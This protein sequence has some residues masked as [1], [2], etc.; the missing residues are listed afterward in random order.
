MVSYGSIR[1]GF[2]VMGLSGSVG[3]GD[4]NMR[5]SLFTNPWLGLSKFWVSTSLADVILILAI[6]VLF[7]LHRGVIVRAMMWFIHGVFPGLPGL[8]DLVAIIVDDILMQICGPRRIWEPGITL[9]AF[10]VKIANELFG[11]RC[12]IG[13]DYTGTKSNGFF[14][15]DVEFQTKN[16]NKAYISQ[17]S[18][19][20]YE[21]GT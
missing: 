12:I 13:W 20:V 6:R 19:M 2:S 8:L 5:M 15:C 17:S 10:V 16:A 7:P 21:E 9:E 1:D 4:L 11:V 3:H 18:K 14:L